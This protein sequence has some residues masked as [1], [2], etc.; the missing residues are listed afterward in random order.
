MNAAEY[1]ENWEK[2]MLRLAKAE[3][4]TRPAWELCHRQKPYL[5]SERMSLKKSERL[6]SLTLNIP[7]S[8]GLTDSQQ[9]RVIAELRRRR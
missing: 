4:Q 3:I 1:G 7:C 8:A 6:H 2:L 9:K 5:A